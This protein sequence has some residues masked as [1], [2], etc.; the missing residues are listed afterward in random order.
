MSEL[1]PWE[2]RLLRMVLWILIIKGAVFVFLV[3][4]SLAIAFI[5]GGS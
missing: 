4:T 1:K 5:E 3:A 2:K